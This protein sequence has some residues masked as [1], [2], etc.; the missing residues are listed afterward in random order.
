MANYNKVFLMGNL[1]RDPEIRYLQ[2]GRAVVR[3]GMAVNRRYRNRTTQEMVEETTF[4]DLEGWGPQAE[5]FSRYMS[6]GR[7]V[8]VE[9]RLRLDSWENKEGQKR[10]KL[11]VVMDS[12]QFIDSNQASQ[13][14]KGGPRGD[15]P[16][17][18]GRQAP[19]GKVAES[20]QKDAEDYDFDD[21]PF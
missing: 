12:F 2:S 8:F 21:I 3:F 18:P 7:P 4:V 1:T 5:T 10:S 20:G 11:V 13:G 15:G 6:K 16:P 9:G 14:G 19:A 17:P